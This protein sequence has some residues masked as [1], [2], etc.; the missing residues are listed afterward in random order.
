MSPSLARILYTPLLFVLV[1]FS[2]FFIK[3]F[4]LDKGVPSYVIIPE[5]SFSMVFCA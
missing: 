5:I 4:T 1:P 2:E 3:I